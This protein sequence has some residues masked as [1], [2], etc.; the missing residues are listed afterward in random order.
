MTN[1]ELNIKQNSYNSTY[2]TGYNKG[3]SAGVKDANLNNKA[4]YKK[5]KTEA[6]K[7]GYA[8]AKAEYAPKWTKVEDG[9]P[10]NGERVL[11]F[12]DREDDEED[13]YEIAERHLIPFYEDEY[14]WVI[15]ST[16]GYKYSLY[17]EDVIAWMPIP[18]YEGVSE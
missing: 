16:L 8:D 10:E 9:L 3:Y 2:D 15:F 13:A 1:Y 17:D 18:K 14:E 4:N 12:A 11:I 6:Y 5:V 7:K